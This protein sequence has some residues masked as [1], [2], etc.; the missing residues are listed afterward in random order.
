MKK[1]KQT[2]IDVVFNV[3]HSDIVEK[4]GF[5]QVHETTWKNSRKSK[6]DKYNEIIR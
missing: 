6:Q 3:P 1:K 2:Y 5:V 4:S